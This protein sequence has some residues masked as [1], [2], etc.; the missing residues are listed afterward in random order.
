[1]RDGIRP[2]SE[3]ESPFWFL[4]NSH[5]E[6]FQTTSQTSFL[7]PFEDTDC[8]AAFELRRIFQI[9]TT[10][11]LSLLQANGGG[12]TQIKLW[13]FISIPMN[14]RSSKRICLEQG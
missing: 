10:S 9:E 7:E 3:Q 5:R 14:K 12:R 1:M 4:R 8:C 11:R 6:T 2:Q 13:F